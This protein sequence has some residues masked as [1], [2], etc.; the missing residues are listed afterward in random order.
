MDRITDAQVRAEFSE[1]SLEKGNIRKVSDS[2][3]LILARILRV[4]SKRLVVDVLPKDEQMPRKNVAL[5]F[6]GAG[7]RHFLGAMPEVGDVC[8][9]GSLPAESGMNSS[10][11]V[12]CWYA[13]G[14]KAG[15]EW[16]P[17]SSHA[18]DEIGVTPAEK[19]M[20]EGFLNRRRYKLRQMEP[21]HI[22]ASSSQGADLILDESV[23]LA[24]RRGNEIILRDQDQA[25][26]MRSLQ[27]FSVGAGYRVYGGMVQRDA[28]LLPSQLI[29]SNVAWSS[30]RQVD[31]SEVPL[32][33]SG[34]ERNT[35]PGNVKLSYVFDTAED[36][37][38][39]NGLQFTDSTNPMDILR[40]GLFIGDDGTL[41]DDRVTRGSTYGGK[42]IY[43]VSTDLNDSTTTPG[44]E[45]FS[46]Y[47]IE[48]NHTSDGVLPVSEQSD[49]IDIDR[50]LP[51]TPNPEDP[52]PNNLSD[53]PMVEFVLGTVVGNNPT[54][55]RDS[56]G[57][58][59][60]AKVVSKD[61]RRQTEIRPYG[62]GDSIDDQIAFLL[63][64]RNPSDPQV[65]S[66]IGITKGGAYLS[67]FQGHGSKVVQEDFRTGK[68]SFYG[69]DLDGQSWEVN[70]D[71][72][73]VINNSG[74]ARSTDNIGLD[75]TS[76]T[77]AVRISSGGFITEGAA[78]TGTGENSSP[79]K[80][81]IGMK[82]DSSTGTQISAVD[83][84]EIKS[85]TVA[86]K[87]AKSISNTA[88][89]S[90]SINSGDTVS[91]TSKTYSSSINGYAEYVYGGPKDSLPTNGASR[92]T[93]FVA[94]PA[95]GATGGVVDQYELLFGARDEL[96]RTGRHNTTINVGSFNVNTMGNTP[97]SVGPGAGFNIKT[98]LPLLDNSVSANPFSAKLAA[99]AGNATVSASKG[100][101][102]VTGTLGVTVRSAAGSI[103]IMS[104]FVRVT[105]AG[106]PGGVLTDGCIDSLTGKPFSESGTVGAAG[107]RLG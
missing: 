98:G 14:A 99:N 6:P 64:V 84:V 93:N 69:S 43:R 13:P 20:Y 95:T 56:Y 75:F 102:T 55:E 50:L 101:V 53:S 86:I 78:S 85:S 36:G 71:G 94:S 18:P 9:L 63:R 23:S 60:V 12:L 45:T 82:L 4:D 52:D 15:Y 90:F 66:F 24:N 79:A 106:L 3:P 92:F 74:N 107:F 72:T 57:V 76:S 62:P 87:D 91:V 2:Y 67:S 5:S 39:I 49:G 59:L 16:V 29:K 7:G 100:A 46:E 1:S 28:T 105:A 68:Q 38:N 104:P 30:S 61:G 35:D 83:K 27:Q 51:N 11:V 33:K 58:P 34:M 97:I 73:I 65:S 22:I 8:V 19:V 81:R 40:R 37:S 41:Y 26:L 80:Q 10:P 48:V 77:G 21:G 42:R 31:G 44:A 54:D 17:V 88:S 89:N 25:I 103:N 96:F 32:P 70:G 47:R